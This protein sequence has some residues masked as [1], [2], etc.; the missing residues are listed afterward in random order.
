MTI[1]RCYSLMIRSR[2]VERRRSG[3]AYLVCRW[4]G[5]VVDQ[6]PHRGDLFL[7]WP[8]RR[9]PPALPTASADILAWIQPG[10][11]GEIPGGEAMATAFSFCESS[12]WLAE[13]SGRIPDDAGEFLAA[14]RRGRSSLA[15]AAVPGFEVA[16]IRPPAV[17]D[18]FAR[19]PLTALAAYWR[20]V[21]DTLANAATAGRQSAHLT[22]LAAVA[23][24]LSTTLDRLR[25][26]RGGESLESLFSP[27]CELTGASHGP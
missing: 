22:T 26:S 19:Q 7:L 10:G 2:L 12:A 18:W 25:T 15:F 9:H 1:Q 20:L 4:T 3:M 21:A 5:R 6:R 14:V 11:P 13:S 27:S 16:P 23:G 17:D 8:E 24:D